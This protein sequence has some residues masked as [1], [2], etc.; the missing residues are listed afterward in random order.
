MAPPS[1]RE[2]GTQR[3]TSSLAGAGSS[4]RPAARH[5]ASRPAHTA[6][7]VARRMARR[8]WAWTGRA[9]RRGS[10]LG[11][12]RHRLRGAETVPVS[13][14]YRVC[15]CGVCVC[16]HCKCV[17]VL[18][19]ARLYTYRL[20]VP[21]SLYVCLCCACRMCVCVCV[22]RM[23][24]YVVHLCACQFQNLPFTTLLQTS[25]PPGLAE[26]PPTSFLGTAQRQTVSAP[27]ENSYLKK[28]GGDPRTRIYTRSI[29]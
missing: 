6:L 11:S 26:I 5:A 15:S 28:R 7:C 17:S 29:V 10:S 2:G 19:I 9:G 12:L 18:F 21:A 27:K 4:T 20:R 16:L 22:Y 25:P 1:H 24:V 23:R 13:Y 14:V 3:L 8:P